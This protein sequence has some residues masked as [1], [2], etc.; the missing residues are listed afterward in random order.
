M[1]AHAVLG[2]GKRDLVLTDPLSL[3]F[4]I[5]QRGRVRNA[6]VILVGRQS[7]LGKDVTHLHPR[8]CIEVTDEENAGAAGAHLP[9]QLLG[10]QC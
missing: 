6:G 9:I 10:R 2:V 4:E 5:Q 1:A 3:R 8:F 7:T